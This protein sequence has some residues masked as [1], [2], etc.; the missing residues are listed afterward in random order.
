M[1]MVKLLIE[2]GAN[3]TSRDKV[4]GETNSG[5][6]TLSLLQTFLL[7]LQVNVVLV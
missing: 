2:H 6:L 4:C 1:E 5:F 3:V 7:Q